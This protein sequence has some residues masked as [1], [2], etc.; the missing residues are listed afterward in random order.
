MSLCGYRKLQSPSLESRR[1]VPITRDG[2]VNMV[3]WSILVVFVFTAGGKIGGLG[4]KLIR[5]IKVEVKR[6]D[7][8]GSTHRLAP[9]ISGFGMKFPVEHLILQRWI[10]ARLHWI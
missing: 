3:L 5:D 8:S 7:Q 10:L 1:V 2:F 4:V 9:Y 6:E